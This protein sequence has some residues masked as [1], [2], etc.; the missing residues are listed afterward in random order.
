MTLNVEASL[1]RISKVSPVR[2]VRIFN[3]FRAFDWNCWLCDV[4]IEIWKA[5][6]WTVRTAKDGKHPLTCDECG[7]DD[8]E[9][10]AVA[11]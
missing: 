10:L 9:Q 2:R 7:H 3:L 8:A 11:A 6:G 5:K 1:A 4:C